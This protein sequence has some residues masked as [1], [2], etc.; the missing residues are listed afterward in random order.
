MKIKATVI[1]LGA[2]GLDKQYVYLTAA[3]RRDYAQYKN[4]QYFQF[5]EKG[6]RNEFVRTLTGNCPMAVIVDGWQESLEVPSGFV[7]TE[8]GT[9]SRYGTFAQ[10]YTDEARVFFQ[11]LRNGSQKIL[12]DGE[13]GRVY[14]ALAEQSAPL[15]GLPLALEKDIQSACVLITRAEAR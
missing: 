8:F 4:V 14:G 11:T 1:T 2:F 9:S 3:G 5:K 13:L 6:K 12:L 7:K 15:T 10:E